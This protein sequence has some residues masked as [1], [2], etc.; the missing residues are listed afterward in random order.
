M[1]RFNLQ[2]QSK[3]K[4]AIPTSFVMGIVQHLSRFDLAW[5]N[6]LHISDDDLKTLQSLEGKGVILTPNHADEMDPRVCFEVSRRA[7][8]RFVFM[9]NRE[10][11]NEFYGLA[12]WAL[13]R[14]GAFSV[15]RG[16][17]DIAAKKYAV[18]TVKAAKYPLVV[19]PEGEIFYLN[20]ML[21]PFHSGAI[22]I[23]LQAILDERRSRKDWTAFLLPM[24]IKYKYSESL[25]DVLSVRVQKMEEALGKGMTGESLQLRLKGVLSEILRRKEA[26]LKLELGADFERLLERV[27]TVRHSLLDDV[28][29]KY[30]DAYAAQARTIDKVFQLDSHL[31]E[32]LSET[33]SLDHQVEYTEDLSK[34]NEVRQMVSWRPDYVDEDPSQERLA[35]MVLKMEREL[36]HIKRP[37][38]LGKRDV[39]VKIGEPIDL[40]HYI[41]QYQKE[42]HVLRHNLAEKLRAEIQSFIDNSP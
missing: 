40:A 27:Q 15:E 10:A 42:P 21:Q 2:A 33:G 29:Q 34:L 24:S 22:D 13:Q 12:G 26:K 23:G 32:R 25:H 35:E 6:R 31:R 28:E 11:F 9:C 41:E 30:K 36:F 16:G 14:I 1:G 20:Q 39:T 38:Q 17:H 8:N 3:F 7:K 18:E 4:P 37:G 19:F 5:R